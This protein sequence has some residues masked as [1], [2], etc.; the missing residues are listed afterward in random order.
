[1]QMISS[2][3]YL[4]SIVLAVGGIFLVKKKPEPLNGV[5]YFFMS[6]VIFMCYQASAGFVLHLCGL[7][8]SDITVGTA[9][10]LLAAGCLGGS[11]KK[12]TIQKYDFLISDLIVLII[13]AVAAVGA[14]IHQFG[15][16]LMLPNYETVD[17]ARHITFARA[18]AVNHEVTTDRCF[19]AVNSGLIFE[20]LEPFMKPYMD[21]RI[22]IFTDVFMLFLSGVMFWVLIRKYL[23]DR[24]L[25]LTGAAVTLFYMMGYPLNN[26]VCGTSYLGA[27]ITVSVLIFILADN[28]SMKE[29]YF[30]LSLIIALIGLLTA[31]TIFF[32]IVAVCVVLYLALVHMCDKNILDKRAAMFLLLFLCTACLVSICVIFKRS[33]EG[34]VSIKAEGYMYRNLL[35]DYI[36]LLPFVLYRIFKCLNRKEIPFDFAICLFLTAYIA[37]FLYAVCIGQVSTYYFFKIYYLFWIVPFWMLMIDIAYCDKEKRE[38][39]AV[40]CASVLSL[41]VFVFSGLNTRLENRSKSETGY[42]L[43]DNGSVSNIFRIYAWNFERGKISN[44]HISYASIELFEKAAELNRDPNR[45]VPYIGPYNIWEEFN[46]FA[47]AYQWED[48]IREHSYQDGRSF[49]EWAQADSDYI[50]R[51]YKEGTNQ[52]PE[53]PCLDEELEKYLD[54]LSVVYQNEAGVIYS[55]E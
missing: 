18:V 6:I 29:K 23:S 42:S 26:M 1:M 49:I 28:Y 36:F 20:A 8:V 17:Y 30:V 7:G 10:Y 53:S 40:Y 45:V 31:Y 46:Y 21:Y 14:G 48:A 13:L 35:G 38:L 16:S 37:S 54:S 33:P 27:G 2:F 25:F 5:C 43:N 47:L 51:V 15:S 44:M 39:I 11:I 32:P 4:L 24:F 52:N 41:F 50:C 12:K 22:F 3:V 9:N 55:I 19:M 34:I